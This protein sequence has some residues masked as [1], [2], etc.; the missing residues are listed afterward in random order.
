MTPPMPQARTAI[1]PPR[2]FACGS[3]VVD[4]TNEQYYYEVSWQFDD[5]DVVNGRDTYGA[6]AQEMTYTQCN[7]PSP[8]FGGPSPLGKADQ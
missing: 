2:R 1:K 4:T 6:L 8:T 5:G 3:L 7:T